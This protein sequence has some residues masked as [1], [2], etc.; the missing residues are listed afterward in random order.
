MDYYCIR[1]IYKYVNYLQWFCINLIEIN[2]ILFD[3]VIKWMDE[4]YLVK[5]MT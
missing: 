2:S 4:S 3:L 5:N 1:I